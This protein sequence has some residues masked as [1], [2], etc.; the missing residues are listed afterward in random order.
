MKMKFFLISCI[1]AAAALY[2]NS[3]RPAS[4]QFFAR[5][6]AAGYTNAPAGANY[7]WLYQTTTNGGFG[8]TPWVYTRGGSGFQGFFVGTG[9]AIASASNTYWGMYA[10]GGSGDNVA[11]A[12]RGFTNALQTNTVFKIKWH[13]KGIGF[14]NTQRGGFSLRNGNANS[15]TND[16]DTGAR[17]DFYFIGGGSNEF[18]MIDGTG[19]VETGIPFGSNPFQL[20]F[21][22]LT[23]DSYRMVIKD[24]TGANTLG[25]FANRPLAGSGTINSLAL[26]ALQT[27]GDQ[28]FNNLEISS[29]SLV[30]PDIQ[31]LNPTNNA[32]YVMTTNQLSF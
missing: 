28:V 25:T 23:P 20:E 18:L 12:Y 9:D 3:I 19:V 17:F 31:N 27:D 14:N 2:F 30:P 24:A 13:P 7:A 15:T 1:T 29:T 22:L 11:V 16:F 21:T 8:F 26:Y 10:N 6:D 4:A 5:D 32:I